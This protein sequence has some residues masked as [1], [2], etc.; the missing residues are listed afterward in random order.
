MPLGNGEVALNAWIDP[1]GDLCFYIARSD[2][3][4]DN[5]RLLKIGRV[6]ISLDPPLWQDGQPFQQTLRLEDAT[7][8]VRS[9]EGD[10]RVEL[11]LWVDAHR[12]LVQVRIRT[13]VPSVATAAIEP[14]RTEP[15]TLPSV[16]ASDVHLHRG[17]PGNQHA[18]TVVE[19]DTVLSGLGETVGW[20]HH[21]VKSV[22]PSLTMEVQGLGDFDMEDPLLHRTFGALISAD[23]GRRIDD[24]HVQSPASRAHTFTLPVLTLHP[25]TIAEWTTEAQAVLR[26]AA[27]TP[28]DARKAAHDAW[29]QDFWERSWIHVD[30]NEDAE[31]GATVPRNEYPLKIGIDQ[32]GQNRFQGE[33]GRVTVWRR[34]LSEN[35]LRALARGTREP[36]AA[37]DATCVGSWN[38]PPGT[39][40]AVDPDVL[41]GALTL[42]AWV[43]PATMPTHGGRIVDKVTPGGGDGFL[44]DTYPGNS[45]R[46]IVGREVLQKRDIL[47]PDKW[48]HVA[49]VVDPEAGRF[50]LYHDGVN[51]AETAFENG[52]DTFVI[53]RAYALQR[54][55]TACAGRGYYPIKFNGS[56]FTVAAAGQPG[57]A[58]YRRWGPGYWWQNTRLPYL[59][60]CAAGDAEMMQPLFR[61][62]GRD[63]MPLF[64]HRTRAYFGHG[65]AFIPECIYFWGAVFSETYGW[66]PA[67]ERTDKLQDNRYHKW[68]WVAG[69]E[70]LWMMLHYYD[71]TRDA[72]FLS[73]TLI[74]AATE[75]LD[76]FDQ[77]YDTGPDGN[78]VMHPAQ[79]LETWWDCTD[80]MPE[81]AGLYACTERLL[82]LPEDRT[83]DSLRRRWAALHEKLPPLPTRT[84]EGIRMLA[85]AA[86]FEQK[87]NC[88]NPELYA[89]FPFRRIAVGRPDL[90]L[91][92]E[93]LNHRWDRGHFGWRQDDV[94]M[95]FLGLADQAARGLVTRARKRDPNSRFPAFWG[96]NYDWVPDQDHGGVLMK[97]LQAMIM[98]ID[99]DR[100][101]IL[102][103]W[104]EAWNLRFRLHAPRHTLV[105]GQYENGALTSLTVTPPERRADVVLDGI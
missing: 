85:P 83:P 51:V 77:H 30:A 100:I 29:W 55:M 11:E 35:D 105:E 73:D 69:P 104:P 87:R 88:E 45:L 33:I 101:F 74:P 21:N 61:M 81:L 26:E 80:P 56:L 54:F 9:G 40:R 65:G 97:A 89:V 58:D 13:A 84:V 92:I 75:I 1:G 17:N 64:A 44:L 27:A 59:S 41:T 78:M 32:R 43:K 22:G 63:L 16:E 62:Y 47:S 4:G 39:D 24:L 15:V 71:Y 14:W 98:Q 96:P 53:S 2:A 67:T 76:F 25:A 28:L 38:L 60:M 12:P 48:H 82:S 90:D 91:G 5:G 10:R 103:A 102:P 57:D 7:L 20:V 18:P 50:V 99:G 37:G 70:L 49:A 95:A 19:P 3:W 86:R 42:E 66:T 94:F 8:L 79:A 23:G 52:N 46:F 6:R 68:E 36:V 72:E 31:T 93:A 34:A